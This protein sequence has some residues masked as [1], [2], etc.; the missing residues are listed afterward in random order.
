MERRH[1]FSWLWGLEL[2]FLCGW[3]SLHLDSNQ[4]IKSKPFWGAEFESLESGGDTGSGCLPEARD[5]AVAGG[6]NKGVEKVTGLFPACFGPFGFLLLYK[7]V[8][9]SWTLE[10]WFS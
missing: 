8:R 7:G 2:L 5:Q 10:G 3:R 1:P 6:V 4:R 9:C